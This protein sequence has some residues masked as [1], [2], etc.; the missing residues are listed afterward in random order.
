MKT[1]GYDVSWINWVGRQDTQQFHEK[2]HHFWEFEVTSHLNTMPTV[3]VNRD[4]LLEAIGQK[5]MSEEAFDEL[6][7]EFGIELDEV[8]KVWIF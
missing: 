5:G 7:F 6:C 2:F 1:V 4:E 8:V 3:G